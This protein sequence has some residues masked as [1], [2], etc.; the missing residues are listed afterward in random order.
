M[1]ME[2]IKVR[3]LKLIKAEKYCEIL[4]LPWNEL[5]Y[6]DANDMDMHRVELHKS[7]EAFWDV[8]HDF[9][10]KAGEKAFEEWK[11]SKN[12]TKAYDVFVDY[13]DEITK[14]PLYERHPDLK[15]LKDLEEGKV[16]LGELDGMPETGVKQND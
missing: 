9:V 13:L 6:W 1:D 11:K 14:L 15:F 2:E 8:D 7:I 12:F 4:C 5:E 10:T 16:D 3:D